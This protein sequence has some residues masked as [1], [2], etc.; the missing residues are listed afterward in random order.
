MPSVV[1][2]GQP[3]NFSGTAYNI[4][5]TAVNVSVWS[6]LVRNKRAL[7]GQ[8]NRENITLDANTSVAFSL[9]DEV[10][11]HS[12]GNY[13]LSIHFDDGEEHE[14]HVPL[15]ILEN[16][17]VQNS[18]QETQSRA[19]LQTGKEAGLAAN[20]ITGDAVEQVT[21][22]KPGA[23]QEQVYATASHSNQPV[24]L[25]GLIVLLSCLCCYFVIKSKGKKSA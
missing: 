12:E 2:N 25:Y 20:K 1:H 5:T 8:H 10:P 22:S 6:Q 3:L 19:A 4:G 24:V 23:R 14:L 11:E 7:N 15:I 18:F 17:K 21:D 16:K 13:T 9:V